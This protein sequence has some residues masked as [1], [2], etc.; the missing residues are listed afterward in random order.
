M[1]SHPSSPVVLGGTGVVGRETLRALRERGADP[2]S[3]AR[4]PDT[5]SDGRTLA[6]DLLA[7]A[8]VDRALRGADTAFFTVGLPYSS[9][10]WAEQWPVILGN[11]IDAA[12]RH[13]VHLVYFDNVYA[14]GRS[15]QPMT[16]RTPIAPVSRKGRVRAAALRTLA[17]AA[18][19]GLRFTVG[20]SAD[21]YGPGA[22]TSVFNTF[23]VDRIVAGKKGTW[24][25]DADQPHSM[26]FTPDIGDALALL[27]AES[28]G[29]GQTWH[30]PTAPPLTGSEYVRLAAGPTA[31]VSVLGAAA[32]R[33]GALFN[34]PARETLEMAYQYTSP[35]VFDSS[36]FEST[37]GVRATPAADAVAA[38]VAASTA[39]G[40]GTGM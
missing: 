26:T 31:P 29:S 18:A 39:R 15:P 38:T 32:M 7:A 21:F 28:D 23:A 13:D 25:F 1:S 6:A 14:Y 11:A 40:P 17:D 22:A 20:R 16:E 9:R 2:L 24:L 4:R 8:D 37:F 27:G 30:L 5:A 33:L 12:L 19:R 10:V 35:Y 36:A 3:V 34:G